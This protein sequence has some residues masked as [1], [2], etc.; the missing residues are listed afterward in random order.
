[1]PYNE[2]TN[3]KLSDELVAL[4]EDLLWYRC[5][6]KRIVACLR[7]HNKIEPRAFC[8]TT[9]VQTSVATLPATVRGLVGAGAWA[10]ADGPVK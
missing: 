1:M 8:A 10:A 5:A 4:L 2:V 9:P 3:S 7:K 6:Q